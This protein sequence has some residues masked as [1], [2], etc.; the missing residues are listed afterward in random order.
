MIEPRRRAHFHANGEAGTS[1]SAEGLPVIA[2]RAAILQQ[3]WDTTRSIAQYR[4]R[5]ACLIRQ[6]HLPQQTELPMSNIIS[7]AKVKGTAIAVAFAL[8]LGALTPAGAYNYSGFRSI[9]AHDYWRSFSVHVDDLPGGGA[10][11]MVGEERAVMF[12]VLKE[13]FIMSVSAQSWHFKTND[14]TSVD[15]IIKGK[16]YVIDGRAAGEHELSLDVGRDSDFIDRLIRADEL[17]VNVKGENWRLHL[18][19]LDAALS[20]ALGVVK[21]IDARV[22]PQA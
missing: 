14:Q 18:G 3:R 17:T 6:F 20:D 10:I 13:H 19:G 5:T 4:A 15:V 7:L 11:S 2:V 1:Q 21:K 9:A 12:L 16:K 8:S 22:P